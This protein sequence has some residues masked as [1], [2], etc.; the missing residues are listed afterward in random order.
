MNDNRDSQLDALFRA[1]RADAPDT[2]RAEYGF[3][4]RLLARLRE[5][6]GA[7]LFSW[8]WKLAPFFAAVAM[9]A[10]W[11]GQLS[12]VQVETTASAVAEV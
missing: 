3:E 4:T 2:A 9:A 11:W 6:R 5:E 10:V 8:A 7:S 12:I 1:A